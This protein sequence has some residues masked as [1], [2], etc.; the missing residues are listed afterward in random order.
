MRSDR[1]ASEP[2]DVVSG[3]PQGSVLG[4]LLFIL[5]TS[6]I[7]HIIGNR[8]VSYTDDTTTYAIIRGPL[9]R[10]QMMKSLNQDVAFINA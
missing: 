6:E 5:Y 2:V 10:P 8:I 3:V 4:S 1:K 9:L 7:F